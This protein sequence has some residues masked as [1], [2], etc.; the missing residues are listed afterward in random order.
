MKQLLAFALLALVV[1][2]CGGGGDSMA[3]S[4]AAAPGMRAQ[5]QRRLEQ[6]SVGVCNGACRTYRATAATCSGAGTEIG[7]RTYFRCRVEYETRGGH[8]PAP[9]ELCAAL[10][11]AQGHLARPLGNCR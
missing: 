9:D 7:G 11:D 3:P 5:L 8:T 4:T 2:A 6:T 10:D 1:P